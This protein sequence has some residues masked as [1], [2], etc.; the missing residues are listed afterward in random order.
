MGIDDIQ[1]FLP[2][3]NSSVGVD[4]YAKYMVSILENGNHEQRSWLPSFFYYSNS[5]TGENFS[6]ELV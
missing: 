1:I 5:R 4:C 2:G 6:F 3:D